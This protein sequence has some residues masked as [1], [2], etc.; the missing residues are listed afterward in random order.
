[1]RSHRH[2]FFS[3][4]RPYFSLH[5]QPR[6][7]MLHPEDMTRRRLFSLVIPDVQCGQKW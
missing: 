4:L 5:T 3:H 6:E 2:G 1:M 7:Q